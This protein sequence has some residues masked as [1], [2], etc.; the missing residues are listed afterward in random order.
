MEEIRQETQAESITVHD[1]LALIAVVGRGMVQR[2]GVC[3]R[4]FSALGRA[5]V[6]VYMIDSGSG[7]LNIIIGVDA[8]EFETAIR[9]LYDEFFG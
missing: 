2:Q 1:N 3:Q 4:V 6:N 5:K 7:E 8:D 9:A